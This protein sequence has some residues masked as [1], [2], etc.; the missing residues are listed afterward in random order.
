MEPKCPLNIIQRKGTKLDGNN[1]TILYCY[2][3]YG[4]NVD[5]F[6]SLRLRLMLD[7][8]VV[9]VYANL[10]GGAE[11]GEAWHQAG[12]L[13]KKTECFDDFAA[14]A[15][16]LI[17]HHYTA[18]APN[19]A[20]NVTEFGTVKEADHFRALYACS[21]YHHVREGTQYPAILFLTGANYPRVDPARLNA[22]CPRDCSLLHAVATSM[23]YW[24]AAGP[25]G[26][27]TGRSGRNSEGSG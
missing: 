17:D 21:P 3:G 15:Q 5:P 25:M 2:G 10:R 4:I 9:Y 13:T 22:K 7:R 19:G 26:P 23:S 8:E 1:P 14:S 20:F 24:L 27:F 6:Y 12:M 18:P 16:W 11:F